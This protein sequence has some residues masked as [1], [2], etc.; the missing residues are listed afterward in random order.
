MPAD[1]KAGDVIRPPSEI[2]VADSSSKSKVQETGSPPKD[3]TKANTEPKQE[4]HSI[5]PSSSAT[6]DPAAPPS[7]ESASG[8]SIPQGIVYNGKKAFEEEAMFQGHPKPPVGLKGKARRKA[9]AQE[10][11]A[12]ADRAK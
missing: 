12:E 2:V 4:K 11:S 6:V 8:P 3:E 1:Q 5:E 10:E 7:T 9:K